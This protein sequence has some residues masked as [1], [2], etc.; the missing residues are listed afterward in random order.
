MNF[1]N[2]EYFVEATKD[3]NLTHTAERLHITQQSLGEHISKLERQFDTRLFERKTPLRLTPSGEILL[4]KAIQILEM[5]K[6]LERELQ[7][8][9]KKRRGKLRLAIMSSSQAALTDE[10]LS[11]FRTRFPGVELQF[12]E[13]GT[14]ESTLDKLDSGEAELALD[15]LPLPRA[16]YRTFPIRY[17]SMA[18]IVHESVLEQYLPGQAEDFCSTG[19]LR[20]LEHCPLLLPAKGGQFRREIDRIYQ[21]MSLV[22]VVKLETVGFEQNIE[23]CLHGLG[24]AFYPLHY[25]EQVN[26]QLSTGRPKGIYIVPL[27]GIS[28]TNALIW[29]EKCSLSWEAEAFLTLK[30]FHHK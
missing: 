17:D 29:K 1:L 5:Q 3:C 26:P 25:L 7:D 9:K 13:A 11:P 12:T 19:Y 21:Q 6:Q 16:G 27:A 10:L 23:L 20:L 4:E 24:A 30:G 22:P 18:A 28:I 2:L 14:G 15:F 8:V